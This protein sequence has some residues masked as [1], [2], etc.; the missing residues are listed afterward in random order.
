MKTT[1]TLTAEQIAKVESFYIVYK[2]TGSVQR[3]KWVFQPHDFDSAFELWSDGYRTKR[4][5]M[6]AAYAE[7]PFLPADEDEDES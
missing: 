6:A 3:G 4:E 7:L 5:A 1:T 2:N